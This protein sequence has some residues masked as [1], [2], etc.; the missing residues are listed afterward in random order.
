MARHP[1][2][3]PPSDHARTTQVTLLLERASHLNKPTPLYVTF[4]KLDLPRT[5]PQ[6]VMEERK[7]EAN[8]EEFLFWIKLLNCQFLKLKLRALKLRKRT[9]I[10]LLTGCKYN[11]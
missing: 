11:I 9:S 2:A 5:S 1:G 8:K 3:G 7:H 6:Y 10:P 4:E